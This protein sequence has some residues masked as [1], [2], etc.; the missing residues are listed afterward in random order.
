MKPAKTNKNQLDNSIKANNIVFS[1]CQKLQPMGRLDQCIPMDILKVYFQFSYLFFG[2]FS[3][4]SN[5]RK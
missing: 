1:Y 5:F 3:Q 2:I 4:S